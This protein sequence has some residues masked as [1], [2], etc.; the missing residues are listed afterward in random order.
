M[1][2][3]HQCITYKCSIFMSHL[4]FRDLHFKDRPHCMNH[5]VA[6]ALFGIISRK[7][8]K[9]LNAF[10]VYLSTIKAD[11]NEVHYTKLSMHV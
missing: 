3:N 1:Y 11:I 4:E 6:L 10:T 8:S 2:D 7:C 5:Y 9:M